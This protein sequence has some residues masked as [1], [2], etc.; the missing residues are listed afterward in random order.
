M[1]VGGHYGVC[2]SGF[3][4]E[5]LSA[6]VG[7]A[8]HS[9]FFGLRMPTKF[10][11]IPV[12]H[13]AQKLGVP[14]E[15]I[16]FAALVGVVLA[17]FASRLKNKP[18]KASSSPM[19]PAT[20]ASGLLGFQETGTAPKTDSAGRVIVKLK[21]G[22]PGIVWGVN[23]S[24]LDY[25]VA[26]K[27]AGKVNEDEE[28][29]KSIKVR[30]RPDTNSQFENSVLVETADEKLIGWILKDASADAVSV[31]N[32]IQEALVK[33]APELF[34]QLFTFEV[35]AKIEGFWSEIGEDDKE[36]WEADIELMEIKIKAPA[37]VE[38]D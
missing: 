9:P 5:N 38:I 34:G 1:P 15:Y 6:F 31:M 19:K 22:A 12:G 7:N 18:T 8:A 29:S 32:Q 27:L 11:R 16:F 24:H 37:E 26:N 23:R 17:V 36:E 4:G 33:T 20:Q 21:G 30:I 13:R 14:L 2:Q 35:S 25:L 3:T 10:D 28:F